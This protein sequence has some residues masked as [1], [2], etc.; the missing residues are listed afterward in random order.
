VALYRRGQPVAGGRIVSVISNR[1]PDERLHTLHQKNERKSP[2]R[3]RI[4]L[5]KKMDE[6]KA[7]KAGK[8]GQGD[9]VSTFL[10]P[11]WS[12]METTI[13]DTVSSHQ[14]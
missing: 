11:C 7:K 13:T 9:I 12:T 14:C 4:R 2:S 6:I 3:K 10:S 5:D 8:E 1:I